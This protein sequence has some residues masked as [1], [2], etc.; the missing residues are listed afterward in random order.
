M[1]S[2]HKNKVLTCY[3]FITFFWKK[4]SMVPTCTLTF[5]NTLIFVRQQFAIFKLNLETNDKLS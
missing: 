4:Y 2:H 1:K 3:P 5:S